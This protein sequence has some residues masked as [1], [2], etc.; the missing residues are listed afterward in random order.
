[1]NLWKQN[2]WKFSLAFG[3]TTYTTR[4]TKNDKNLEI[5]VK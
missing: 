5:T 4:A 3:K 2:F 1:M